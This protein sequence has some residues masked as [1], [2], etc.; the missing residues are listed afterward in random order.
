VQLEAAIPNLVNK[1]RHLLHADD[2]RRQSIESLLVPPNDGAAVRHPERRARFVEGLRRTYGIA[3][4]THGQVR[5]LRNNLVVAM[6]VLLVVVAS[7]ALAGY[8]APDALPLCALGRND[9]DPPATI[10]A[11]PTQEQG[12]TGQTTT[13]DV[14]ADDFAN[15]WDVTFV[16][17]FGLMGATLSSALTVMRTRPGTDSPYNLPLYYFLL[18]LPAG[19][20]TAIV[21]LF[22]VNGDF[23]PG[24]SPLET[25]AQI[26]GYAVLFGAAQ[27]I[28]TRWIDRQ[29]QELLDALPGRASGSAPVP[30]PPPA[31]GPPPRPQPQGS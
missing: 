23:I 24:L 22:L 26:L 17:L 13:V 7:S 29:A 19:S 6:L 15:A 2:P 9:T 3:D 21:G 5:R 30:Q 12:L 1:A 10:V 18:K 14:Q 20:L 31:G 27:Q 16:A 25:Q 28:F 11:C 8:L 4:L